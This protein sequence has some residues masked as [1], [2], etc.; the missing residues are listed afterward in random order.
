LT[1]SL[2]IFLSNY[3]EEISTITNK[4]NGK[5]TQ[6]CIFRCHTAGL[7]PSLINPATFCHRATLTNPELA[8]LSSCGLSRA[9][10]GHNDQITYLIININNLGKNHH[11]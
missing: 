2:N 7:Q 10:S 4:I 3:G 9:R 5:T 8:R 11:Q 6:C 1:Y